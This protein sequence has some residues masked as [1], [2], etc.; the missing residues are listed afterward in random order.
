MSLGGRTVTS[1]RFFRTL[2]NSSTLSSYVA[3]HTSHVTHHVSLSLVTLQ[4]S[5]GTQHAAVRTGTGDVWVWGNGARG[6]LGLQEAVC[7]SLPCKMPLPFPPGSVKKVNISL[8]YCMPPATI[9]TS[10]HH[11]SGALWRCAHGCSHVLWQSICVRRLSLR[12]TWPRLCAARCP[13]THS[14]FT[15]SRFCLRCGGRGR[16]HNCGHTRA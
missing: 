10:S 16:V 2:S 12:S 4:C 15:A 13:L 8:V 6:Q 14:C 1:H 11:F 5:M 7:T 3:F 9:S